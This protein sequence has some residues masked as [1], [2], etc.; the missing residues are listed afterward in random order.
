[1][2]LPVD[3]IRKDTPLETVRRL[4]SET[5]RALIEDEEKEP[6]AATGQAYSMAEKK[7]GKPI[8]R[9]EK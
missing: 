4:I 8:P 2:P 9:G 6:N 7:W 3:Q 5:I 1:M